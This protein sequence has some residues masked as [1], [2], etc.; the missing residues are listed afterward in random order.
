MSVTN[1]GQA[2][3][4]LETLDGV[5]AEV[6]RGRSG[7]ELSVMVEDH[8][9]PDFDRTVENMSVEIVGERYI[10]EHYGAEVTLR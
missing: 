2:K 3:R 4:E 9:R 8:A 5:R 10:S 6:E 1:L 7:M